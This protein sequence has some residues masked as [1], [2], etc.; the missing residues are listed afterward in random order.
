MNVVL[1]FSDFQKK[2]RDLMTFLFTELG[3]P[4]EMPLNISK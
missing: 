2:R 3:K 4:A 1:Q